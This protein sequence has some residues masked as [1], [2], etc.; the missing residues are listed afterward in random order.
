[1]NGLETMTGLW[2]EWGLAFI[3]IPLT[4][5]AEQ[6]STSQG[7]GSFTPSDQER[8]RVG[9]T[10]LCGARGPS[11]ASWD[12]QAAVVRPCPAP[13]GACFLGRC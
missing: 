12:T 9:T 4:I 8:L 10:H 7:V 6:Q 5:K 2:F 13:A 11:R 1:M 3:F